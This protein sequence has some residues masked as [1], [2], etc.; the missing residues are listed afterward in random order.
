[1][2]IA[3]HRDYAWFWIP[4]WF[5]SSSETAHT[6]D[7]VERQYTTWGSCPLHFCCRQGPQIRVSSSCNT[8]HPSTVKTVRRLPHPLYSQNDSSFIRRHQGLKS[9]NGLNWGAP[10]TLPPEVA[11]TKTNHAWISVLGTANWVQRLLRSWRQKKK[12]SICYCQWR[13]QSYRM[14]PRQR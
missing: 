7:L 6:R 10:V 9:E 13:L 11:A 5:F 12:N 4:M 1:M 8:R 14:I 2:L 3:E